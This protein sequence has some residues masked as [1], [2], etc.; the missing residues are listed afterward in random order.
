MAELTHAETF[1]TPLTPQE[2]RDRVLAHFQSLRAKV[3]VHDEGGVP[4]VEARTGSQAKMRILGGAFI[5]NTS[6]PARTTVALRP[7]AGGTEVTA[8][9]SDAVG[10]GAKVG[11]K[12]KYEALLPEL[13]AGVRS[14]LAS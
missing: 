1:T 2:G 13:V 9:A 12:G 11:M 4:Q 10:F 5:A 8:T 14:A 3:T 7:G 6:L